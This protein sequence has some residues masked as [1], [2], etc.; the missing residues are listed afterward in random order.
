[1]RLDGE[2]V[3]DRCRKAEANP[4][5]KRKKEKAYQMPRQDAPRPADWYS[6]RHFARPVGYLRACVV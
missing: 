2:Q 4:W 1:M 3:P 5:E 6:D